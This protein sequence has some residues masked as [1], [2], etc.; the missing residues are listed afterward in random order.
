MISG[1]KVEVSSGCVGWL[2]YT[3]YRGRWGEADDGH[4]SFRLS[5]D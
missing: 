3:R 2:R 1:L 4:W 5:L